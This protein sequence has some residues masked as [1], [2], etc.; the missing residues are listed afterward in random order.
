MKEDYSKL[1]ERA[2]QRGENGS[3]GGTD[4]AKTENKEKKKVCNNLM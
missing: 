3:L 4:W 1:K 2:G